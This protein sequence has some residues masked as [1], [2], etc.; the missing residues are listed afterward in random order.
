MSIR[1]IDSIH[2]QEP[3]ISGQSSITTN[4]KVQYLK[5]NP[6]TQE[7]QLV[8]DR[9]DNV[10]TKENRGQISSIFKDVLGAIAKVLF[11]PI[12]LGLAF[13]LAALGF[14]AVCIGLVY[15]A[16]PSTK[17]DNKKPT[18]ETGLIEQNKDQEKLKMGANLFTIGAGVVAL[19]ANAAPI[20]KTDAEP[21]TLNELQP[22]TDEKVNAEMRFIA[23]FEDKDENAMKEAQQAWQKATE[24][25]EAFLN[26]ILS[27][28]DQFLEAQEAIE[29]AFKV[30]EEASNKVIEE[31]KAK[32]T[33]SK[34]L[35]NALNQAK[36]NLTMAIDNL[37]S[38]Q[39]EP[40]E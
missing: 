17:S 23:A 5:T 22:L 11:F 24:N 25:I 20:Q 13:G 36:A 30:V 33:T 28:E 10:S 31:F 37:K 14:A 15:K 7:K 26:R 3:N 29:D 9:V 35:A 12:K 4:A 40:S 6:S 16:L 27:G 8:Q 38:L 2:S 1:G 39:E 21:E 19:A 32:G 34:E 18:N